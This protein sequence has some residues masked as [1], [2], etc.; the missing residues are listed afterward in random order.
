[1]SN[2]KEN[3]PAKILLAKEQT[4]VYTLLSFPTKLSHADASVGFNFSHEVSLTPHAGVNKAL[5]D[6]IKLVRYQMNPQANWGPARAAVR[7]APKKA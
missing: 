6:N 4:L 3:S 5:L 7:G 2:V 1:M